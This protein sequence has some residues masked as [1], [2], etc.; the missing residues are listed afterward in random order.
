MPSVAVN[1]GRV[2][3]SMW[4]TGIADNDSAITAELTSS[5]Y[6]PI[7]LDMY[8]NIDNGDVYQYLLA[9]SIL[10][11]S[12]KGN[13]RGA[14]GEG[15][16]IKKTY[17]SVSSMNAGY[18]SDGVP[19]GGFVMISSNVEDP[20]NAKLYVKG[21]TA[22]TFVTDFSGAQGIKGE[23]GEK[24]ATG[25]QGEKGD[26]GEKGD[27]GEIALTYSEKIVSSSLPVSINETK[28]VL[29]VTK[30]NRTP[31]IN[32]TFLVIW[33]TSESYATQQSYVALAK[34]IEI[35][36]N[37]Y[38]PSDGYEIVSYVE[39]TGKQGVQ[40]E[41][42]DYGLIDKGIWVS[43]SGYNAGDLVQYSP[44]EGI[45]NTYKAKVNIPEGSG[46]SKLTPDITTTLWDT[47]AGVSGSG[48]GDNGAR[49]YHEITIDTS[50]WE[51][52]S[53]GKRTTL[54]TTSSATV[55]TYETIIRM[56]KDGNAFISFTLSLA[57]GVHYSISLAPASIV[58]DD[59]AEAIM[60]SASGLLQQNNINKYVS[61]IVQLLI[62][63]DMVGPN[64]G[65]AIGVVCACDYTLEIGSTG[66]TVQEASS[67]GFNVTFKIG[68]NFDKKWWAGT[69]SSA[70]YASV[71]ALNDED[72]GIYDFLRESK[73]KFSKA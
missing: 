11:W 65:R 73:L 68:G 52:E 31:K 33:E 8:L 55:N 5:G 70:A 62:G 6:N 13:L 42:G 37:G 12:Y 71:L 30:F 4:Y 26:K 53:T 58:Y 41:K 59:N 57:S 1:L 28:P 27:I 34:I 60:I 23:K 32:D 21:E 67:N 69:E 40:G 72:N 47:F 45:V 29:D 19:V 10:Q 7:K 44:S 50:S 38:V 56:I 22:Y 51:G 24:G 66:I 15:F 20:D 54:Y 25:A 48:G 14:T 2:K 16:H 63:D 9:G 35:S 49:Y 43:G 17:E 39:T 18:A 3:G 61:G 64:T 36:E 46:N